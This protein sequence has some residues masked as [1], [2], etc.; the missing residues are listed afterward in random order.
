[1]VQVWG[2]EGRGVYQDMHE[3]GS[4]N[5]ECG[6]TGKDDLGKWGKEMLAGQV[7]ECLFDRLQSPGI[8]LPEYPDSVLLGQD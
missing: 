2:D 4:E 3:V 6:S 5:A 7:I 8:A 1:M